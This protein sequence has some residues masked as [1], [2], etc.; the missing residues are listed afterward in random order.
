[1]TK[2]SDY[3][4]K[5]L[6]LVQEASGQLNA[7][8][9]EM[10]DLAASDEQIAALIERLANPTTWAADQLSAISTLAVVTSSPRCCQRDRPT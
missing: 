8:S 6:Q 2:I 5:R 10:L 3:K 7:D 1:M 4:A 9:Q